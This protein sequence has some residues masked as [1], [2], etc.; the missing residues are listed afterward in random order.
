MTPIDPLQRLISPT[1]TDQEVALLPLADGRADLLEEIMSTPVLDRAEPTTRRTPPGWL[2]AGAAAAAVAAIALGSTLG[3]GQPTVPPEQ[4]VI[5]PAAPAVLDGRYIELD[6]AGWELKWVY[7][8]DDNL[9]LDWSSG[10]QSLTLGQIPAELYDARLRNRQGE[11]RATTLLGRDA[12]TWANTRTDY[13]T[14]TEPAGGIFYEIR[15]DGMPLAAYEDLIGGLVPTDEAGFLDALPR[16]TLTPANRDEE[17]RDLLTGATTP[18]GFGLEDVGLTGFVSK[19]YA[20]QGVAGAV[21]CAWLDVY[22]GGSVTE[23]EQA[24]GA[25]DGSRD[26]PV[27]RSIDAQSDYPEVFEMM[28]DDLRMGRSAAGLKPDIC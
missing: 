11:I 7:A 4:R 15:A 8:D 3:G 13:S 24:L 25:F 22:D 10:E 26:W 1:I 21:G 5:Q 16:G 28:A 9:S 19:I 27:L 12:T 18:E 14:V 2:V 17:I 20:A 23:Q 6:A